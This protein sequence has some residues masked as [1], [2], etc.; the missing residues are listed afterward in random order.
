VPS[1]GYIWT[2]DTPAIVDLSKDETD[3]EPESEAYLA[4]VDDKFEPTSRS[5]ELRLG[6]G[7]LRHFVFRSLKPGSLTLRLINRRPWQGNASLNKTFEISIVIDSKNI[8]GLS[9]KQHE[10]LALVGA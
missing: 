4:L 8:Q 1:T 7:G 3:N 10:S 5:G 6:G 2:I 9:E